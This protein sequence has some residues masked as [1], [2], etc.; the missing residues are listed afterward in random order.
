ML[1]CLHEMRCVNLLSQVPCK[2]AAVEDL[3]GTCSKDRSLLADLRYLQLLLS[4]PSHLQK[5][6]CDLIEMRLK[7]SISPHID[8]ELQYQPITVALFQVSCAPLITIGKIVSLLSLYAFGHKVVGMV[9]AF[10][11]PSTRPGHTLVSSSPSGLGST[12]NRVHR[13]IH[14]HPLQL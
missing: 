8:S 2:I 3:L 12:H 7:R 6:I 13:F 10:Q 11:R 14:V 5:E 9:T 1:N 4:D